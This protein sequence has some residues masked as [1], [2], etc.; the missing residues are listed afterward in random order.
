M[1]SFPRCKLR[2]DK[3]KV[4]DVHELSQHFDSCTVDSKLNVFC[5]EAQ[6]RAI[7]AKFTYETDVDYYQDTR[8]VAVVAL[9]LPY[10]T[11]CFANS[12]ILVYLV[13]P[14]NC[15]RLFLNAIFEYQD[16]ITLRKTCCI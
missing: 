4:R 9:N 1:S 2:K 7:R 6:N 5:I 15:T 8:A 3:V 14:N 11:R 12:G 16:P 13:C 10:P